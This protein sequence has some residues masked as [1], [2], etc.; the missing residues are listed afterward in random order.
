MDEKFPCVYLL[1]NRPRGV[2]YTGV[3]SNLVARVWEHK[4]K[5]VD[6]FTRKY[7]IDQLVWYEACGEIYTAIAREKQIK[8]WRRAWK[9]NLIESQN[10]EWKDLYP[11]I[12]G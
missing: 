8:K 6:A 9:I 10:S 1:A 11:E 12:V 5:P 4:S 7:N 3:T 2:L